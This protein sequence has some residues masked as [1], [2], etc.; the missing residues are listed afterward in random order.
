LNRDETALNNTAEWWKGMKNKMLAF[1]SDK[2]L[3]QQFALA[4]FVILLIGMVSMGAWVTSRIESAV[5]RNSALSAALFMDSFVAPLLNE[6]DEG[7]QLSK[8]HQLMLSQLIEQTP[9]GEQVVSFKIWGPEGLVV[10]SSTPGLAGQQFPVTDTLRTAWQGRLQA[11]FDNLHDEEDA[12]ERA[13]D[14]PLLEIYSPIRTKSGKIIAVSEFYANAEEL[15]SELF[16]SRMQ[17]WLL[18]ALAG[19]AM[20][21]ALSG[22]AL[23]GSHVIE[24]QQRALQRR[25]FELSVLRKRLEKASRRSTE[26]N[27]SFLRRVGADLHDGPAQLLALALL[28]IEHLFPDTASREGK[29]ALEREI[30][31]P[32]QDALAE[33]RNLSAGLILPGL[34]GMCAREILIKAANSHQSRTGV[35]VRREF[36]LD[37]G[38]IN[39]PH[40][41]S[42]CVYRFVQET[43]NNAF[44]H[45]KADEAILTARMDN[46][47]FTVVV[48]DTGEGFDQKVVENE[49]SGLGLPGLRE[50]I[51]SVGGNFSLASS[52]GAGTVVSASFL[53]INPQPEHSGDSVALRQS[54]AA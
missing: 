43:L 40:S 47:I 22:I 49:S 18:F 8:E 13:M 4:S 30:R 27:E 45:G 34:E 17:S 21:F 15:E 48:K 16:R 31:E 36:H 7:N 24:N 25:V 20:F 54:S 41:I 50:R 1:W 29:K 11:E 42:I 10:H 46:G 44:Y 23:R 53:I 2:S 39:I 28:K 9:L 3:V 51:E 12:H 33:I 14:M 26:L 52:P 19:L 6:L 38:V 5:V 35:R 32:L 37:S